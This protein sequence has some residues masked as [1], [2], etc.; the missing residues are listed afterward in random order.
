MIDCYD[1]EIAPDPEE[2]LALDEGSRIEQVERFHRN[3]RIPLPKSARHMHAVIHS[4]VEN[5]LAMEDQEIVRAVL[6][7]LILEGLTRHDAV[8]AIGSVLTEHIYDCLHGDSH[9]PDWTAPYYA[10]LQQLTAEKWRHN[11]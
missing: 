4:I 5:Q 3:A 8:H 7:R 2:W 9:L 10:E 6:Q 1:P 11:H